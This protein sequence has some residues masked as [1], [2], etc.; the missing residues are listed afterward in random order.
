MK[1]DK[2]LISLPV[3]VAVFAFL[4]LVGLLGVLAL[5][6]AQPTEAQ[7]NTFER[8]I[9]YEE[10]GKRPVG[11]F[12]ATGL[13]ARK[14][15]WYLEGEDAGDFKLGSFTGRTT[16]LEFRSSPNFED[17]Q[18]AAQAADTTVTPPLEADAA[19][20]NRYQVTVRA[21]DGGANKSKIFRVTVEV[22]N[23]KEDGKISL[24]P[25]QPQ[26]TRQM[27]ADLSDPDRVNPDAVNYAWT[28]SDSMTGSYTPI[29]GALNQNTYTP[30][31]T[32]VGRYIRVK[33]TYRDGATQGE[34]T[35]MAEATSDFMVEAQPFPNADPVFADQNPGNTTTGTDADLLTTRI[36]DEGLPSGTLV[37]P[38]VTA[39]DH[40][41][42]V[43]TYTLLDNE[44]VDTDGDPDTPSNM[45][46]HSTYF[47]IDPKTGQITTKRRLE[48]D[49]DAAATPA[50]APTCDGN[51]CSVV[52]SA[53]DPSE[54]PTASPQASAGATQTTNTNVTVTITINPVNESPGEIT[55]TG[56]TFT[57]GDVAPTPPTNTLMYQDRAERVGETGTEGGDE[58]DILATYTATDPDDL[59]DVTYRLAG[60]DGSKF[61]IGTTAEGETADN[62]TEGALRFK[63]DPNYD[64]PAD[65]NKDNVYELIVVASDPQLNVSTLWVTIKV[66]DVQETG[67]VSF[68]KRHPAVGEP[69]TAELEDPDV[70]S[71]AVSWQWHKGADGFTPDDDNAIA[72]ATLKT[73]R[74]TDD[75][76]T[77]YLKAVATY[78]DKQAPGAEQM[79]GN[80]AATIA[81]TSNATTLPV[82][83]IPTTNT[84]PAFNPDHTTARKYYVAEN[85]ED[86]TVKTAAGGTDEVPVAQLTAGDTAGQTLT[87]SLSGSDAKY[88]KIGGSLDDPD[89]A[90]GTLQTKEELDF[91]DPGRG[92]YPARVTY[93]IMVRAT[94]PFGSTA[95]V[96]VTVIVTD[97]AEDPEIDD[98]PSGYPVSVMVHGETVEAPMAVAFYEN[99]AGTVADFSATDPDGDGIAWSVLPIA[100]LSPNTDPS[101]PNNDAT[102]VDVDLFEINS[103][104][105][106]L[107]FKSPPSYEDEKDG[108]SDTT[109]GA[110]RRDNIYQVTIRARSLDTAPSGAQTQER[111]TND[112]YQL[113]VKVLNVPENPVFR[114]SSSSRS[115][116]E[117]HGLEGAVTRGPDR[118][119]GDTPVTA[120]DPDNADEAAATLTYTLE[121]TDAAS[122]SIV[123]ATGQ[124]LTRDVLDYE[125]RT[126]YSVVVKA[127]DD[128]ETDPAK[129]D[130]TIDIGIDVLDV[131]E[132]IPVGLTVEGQPAVSY[133]E[134]DTVSVGTYTAVGEGADMVRWIPLEGPDAEYFM[135]DGSGSSVML[136]FR[137]S[138]NY[139]MPRGMEM[140]DDNTN[141]YMVTV[142]IEHTPSGGTAE[143]DVVITVTDAA[144]LG[145]L[146]G[147][148]TVTYAENGMD[149][150]DTYMVDGPMA[151]MAMWSLEGDDMAQFELDTDTGSSV[152]LMFAAPPNYEMPRGMEMSNTNTNTYMVTVKAMVG[153]EMAMQDVTISV[154]DVDDDGKV[155]I[156]PTT[157]PMPGT[158]LTAT[159]SDDDGGVADV[160]WQWSRSMTMD[161]TYENISGATSMTYDPVAGDDGYYLRAMAMYS[162]EYGSGKSA[163]ATTTSAVSADPNQALIDMYDTNGNGSIDRSDVLA[164]IDRLLANDPDVTRTDVLALID[165]LLQQ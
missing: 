31:T 35:A 119:I 60:P 52:V 50:I 66:T 142:K 63:D 126:E 102:S 144:E 40:D 122:F 97:E 76:A 108:T 78:N 39:V 103:L 87:Y 73:Y 74:P 28:S 165:L 155:E 42:D 107:T 124:L 9:P 21:G 7:A 129:R 15:F 146:D 53:T 128:T 133:M 116:E 139:E 118:P 84:D 58:G 82:L 2:K 17:P 25:I 123:P 92:S 51:S 70:V 153:G 36:V 41:G 32:D 48:A 134:D 12:D 69:I 64:K 26:V 160:T 38:P 131:L 145:M 47:D 49:T 114:I 55:D 120:T 37:G 44:D 4:A 140:T 137:D 46:G 91:E 14:V 29:T 20:N 157:Q 105:G 88:F 27:T 95:Q 86:E 24:T 34:E 89:L 6:P 159:L 130:D 154:T 136:K 59:G 23:A 1:F 127:S 5:N 30:R 115:R 68:N 112:T 10:N 90:E 164:A 96:P 110:G 141:T 18:D 147:D 162:D 67:E 85:A 61:I 109:E 79:A 16:T 148:G 80:A 94:D 158:V 150:V 33:A 57:V 11:T 138:P 151:D 161:G 163:E 125:T 121:G 135:V 101:T 113:K 75:D 156:T 45:D 152:M 149:A 83:A 81:N 8:L 54:R 13:D 43:L 106:V 3:G 99:G 117:D 22:T 72:G 111:D 56:T 71:G 93:N 77:M 104:T 98:P 62:G 143:H 132:I 100:P 19:M 65:E